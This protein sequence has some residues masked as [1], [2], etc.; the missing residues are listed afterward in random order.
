MIWCGCHSH[1]FG[2]GDTLLHGRSA[3]RSAHAGYASA[4]SL[5]CLHVAPGVPAHVVLHSISHNQCVKDDLPMPDCFKAV[6]DLH[7]TLQAVCAT[8]GPS[9]SPSQ[10]CVRTAQHSSASSALL[11][12]TCC[13]P[14]FMATHMASPWPLFLLAAAASSAHTPC[15]AS[16]TQRLSQCIQAGHLAVRCTL[17]SLARIQLIFLW[18]CLQMEGCRRSA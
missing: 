13:V 9:S 2:D 14:L 15:C 4:C 8:S 7:N 1:M 12:T 17:L 18:D 10:V 3:R 5:A 16:Q 11:F 6:L